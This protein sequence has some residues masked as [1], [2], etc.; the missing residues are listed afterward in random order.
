MV[1][2][3]DQGASAASGGK[4]DVAAVAAEFKKQP[5][6]EKIVGV[7]ALAFLL[8]FTFDNRWSAL[9]K[10]GGPFSN[11]VQPWMHTLGFIGAIGVLFLVITRLFG[12]RLLP[13]KLHGRL[14]VLA[15]VMPAL[16]MLID[17]LKN[18]WGFVMLA[19]LVLMAY[20]GA[21]ITTR[22]QILK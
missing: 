16:G 6:A 10:F 14:L 3:P 18:F 19:G 21:K 4:R 8:A 12:V 20:A 7:A 22:D 17:E 13:D 1:A 5:L 2:S 9:F 11:F 15:A